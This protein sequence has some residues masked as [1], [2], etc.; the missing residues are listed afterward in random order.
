ME[1]FK[2]SHKLYIHFTFIT[3]KKERMRNSMKSRSGSVEPSPA[4]LVRAA[5][6]SVRIPF[7]HNN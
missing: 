6:S 3:N 4:A 1:E 7:P 5:F 2:L